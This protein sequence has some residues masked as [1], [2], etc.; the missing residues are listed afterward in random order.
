VI[1][2]AGGELTLRD[3]D[4]GTQAEETLARVVEFIKAG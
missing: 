3:L 4:A 2:G 1:I